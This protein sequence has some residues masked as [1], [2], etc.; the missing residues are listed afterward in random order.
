MNEIIKR[1]ERELA[2]LG[3]EA[4][5]EHGGRHPR[6]IWTDP[7]DG[8]LRKLV[9]PGTPSDWR[10]PR[11]AVCGLRRLLKQGAQQ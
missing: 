1:L 4:T 11:N 7:I 3:L 10:A 6:V 5:I 8:Q 9:I 2:A